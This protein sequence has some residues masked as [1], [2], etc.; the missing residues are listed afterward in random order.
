MKCVIVLSLVL[1]IELMF[2]APSTG[3]IL[4]Q[5]PDDPATSDEDDLPQGRG[6]ATFPAIDSDAADTAV[7]EEALSA[8]EI[9]RQQ[10]LEHPDRFDEEDL[11]PLRETHI[12][13]LHEAIDAKL[14]DQSFIRTLG[15]VSEPPKVHDATRD[16][17]SIR[18]IVE[19]VNFTH[20]DRVLRWKT[21]SATNVERHVV[22]GLTASSLVVLLERAGQYELSQELV[23]E[24]APIA[25]EVLNFWDT[26]R[27]TAVGCVLISMGNFL[28]WYTMREQAEYRL[29]EEWRW[30]LHKTITQIKFFRQKEVDALLLVGRHPNRH[31]SVS[32]TVY[33]FSFNDRQFWLM[34]KI[35]LKYPC[36]SVGLVSAGEEYL[37][38]FPQNTTV[39]MY[40]FRVGDQNRRK[41]KPVGNYTSEALRSVYAF[42]I[43][44]YSYVAISGKT[45]AVL[46][47]KRGKFYEQKIPTE[48]LEIVEA[49]FEIPARTYRDD[50][51]LL[52]Q[53]RMIFATHEIQRLEAL[54]WNGVSFDLAT[55]IPCMVE[56][57]V[58][59]N[60]VSCMLDVDRTDGLFGAANVQR[61]KSISIVVPRH[62]AHSS[63][64][65]LSI[66]LLSG[67]H[68]ILMKIQEIKET[69]DAFTKIIDYQNAVIEQAQSYVDLME[70]DP[71]VL[72]RQNLSTLDSPM[73]KFADD[74]DLSTAQ[75]TIGQN[76]WRAADF[77]ADLAATVKTVQD[78]ELSVDAMLTELQY[79]VRR[80][81]RSHDLQIN[82]T[83]QVTGKLYV[84][85][86]LHA[87]DMYIQ[88]FEQ[89]RNIEDHLLRFG[90]A[91]GDQTSTAQELHVKEL[92]VEQL[93][94]DHFNGIP[95]EELVYNVDGRVHLD[96]ELVVGG[97]LYTNS[98]LL[99]D[100]GTVN[101]IDLSESLIYFNCKNRRWKNLTLDS[102][103]VMD[104]VHVANKVN[105]VQINL[106]EAESSL[107]KAIDEHGRVLRAKSL[108]ID[109]DLS[110]E[111]I[112]GVPWKTFFNGLVFKNRPMRLR[113][114][115]VDGNVTFGSQTTVQFLNKLRFPEDY[116]LRTGPRESIITGQK[117]FL[118]SL[119]M[120]ALDIDGFVNGI[121]P[122]D[123]ITLHDDQYIPGNVSFD[124]L[125]IEESLDVRGAV[126]GKHMDKFLDNPS[127][128]Q[129]TLLNAACE[130]NEVIVQG[131]IFVDQ[132]DG[133]DLDHFLQSVVYVDEPYVEINASKH[134]RNLQ[135]YE[136]I[137]IESNM[138]GEIHLD[139]LLTKSTDQTVNISLVMGNV[140]FNRAQIDGLFGGINVTE[141][142]T[143]SIKLFGDQHTQATLEFCPQ[144]S[145]LYAK[146]LEIMGT[147][148]GQPRAEFYELDEEI[149]FRDQSVHVS[150]L[151]ASYLTLTESLIDGPSKMLNS[152]HLPTFDAYRFSLS[153]PQT[154]NY[155]VMIDTLYVGKSFAARYLNGLDVVELQENVE[156][157]LNDDY[158]LSG[159]HVIDTL[160][161]DGNVEIGML[162]GIDFVK[163]LHNVIWLD[164]PNSVPSTLH[165][166]QP[167]YVE[168]DVSVAGT[169]NEIPLAAF[170]DN[171]VYKNDA[172]TVVEFTGSKLFTQGFDVVGDLNAPTINNVPVKDFIL[173]NESIIFPGHV[174]T[175]GR[176]Y[177]KE[178]IVT[179]SINGKSFKPIE[180][181][182][183][184][185]NATDTH[186]I[187]GDL[188]LQGHQMIHN[189]EA[190]G[191]WNELMNVSQKLA[192]LVRTN[193]DYYFKGH[194][195]LQ[196]DVHFQHGFTVDFINGYNMT[197]VREEIVY[198]DQQEPIVFTEPV[199]F[200]ANVW[201]GS[202]RVEQD[203]IGKNL[204]G[205]DPDELAKQTL[206]V[207]KDYEIFDKMVFLPGAFKCDHLAATH[208]NGV[209][210][211]AL[212]T[213]HTEQTI[214]HPVYVKQIVVQHPLQVEGLVNGRDLRVER[215]NTVMRYGEQT[216]EASSVFNTIRVLN[217]ATLPKILN[218]APFGDPVQLTDDMTIS[219]PLSFYQ[220]AAHDVHS[221][222]T[223]GGIDFDRWYE[224]SLWTGG[225][226]HQVYRGGLRARKM[227]FRDTIH[228]NGTI[229]GATIGD[230]VRKLHTEK[231]LVESELSKRRSNYRTSCRETQA[232][233]NGTQQGLYFFNYFVQ[234]QTIR[235]QQQPIQSFWT[236][237]QQG[238][239]FLAIN[240]GCGSKFYQWNPQDRV[241]V[242]LF[243]VH[244]GY[245]FEWA[246][247]QD[248]EES[249][250]LITR[251]A[252]TDERCN[253]TGL[254]IWQFKG[255]SL[256]LGKNFPTKDIDS[257]HVDPATLGRFYVLDRTSVLEYDLAGNVQD[258]WDLSRIFESASFAPHTLGVGL[259]L[260][261][262]KQIAVLSRKE[263][264]A[265]SRK[266][267]SH[268]DD[269]L[270]NLALFA[271]PMNVYN[272]MQRNSSYYRVDD[273]PDE[274]TPDV[275][276]LTEPD[277]LNEIGSMQES[278]DTVIKTREPSTDLV[279]PSIHTANPEPRIAKAVPLG[280]IS[281]TENHHF[282][283]PATG[284]LLSLHVGFQGQARRLLV[285]V[286]QTVN[287]IVKGNHDTIRLYSDILQGHLF[288]IIPCNRPSQLTVLEIRDETILAFLEN[289]RKVQLYTYRGRKGFVHWNSFNLASAGVQM[290]S[291]QLPQAPFFKCNLHYLA[292]ALASRE[293]M[294][295][296][297][298]TQGDCGINLQLD[299]GS[300]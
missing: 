32:A 12:N 136:P 102:L 269:S 77:E 260:S 21:M 113:H 272:H 169:L 48:S 142:D 36:P 171:V 280:R 299:C 80:D 104:N 23:L 173:K 297:A 240:F 198:Y 81:T 101:G 45:P 246:S 162:N 94:F 68:P 273:T 174:V 78:V 134:Y 203:L 209:P 222:D 270:V 265:P 230:I 159:K 121:N 224:T 83:V 281:T 175:L 170:L 288:Q 59:D 52:V 62:E 245:V 177:V 133:Y 261:D 293:L 229:N 47:Y 189:L 97:D 112:N 278:N 242:G 202:V 225:R 219:S 144:Y 127:L 9:H 73:I 103:E 221:N 50:M 259:A 228:G 109:G 116:V 179:G 252:P 212:I 1:S 187:K 18:S 115:H 196:E 283:D 183:A 211:S 108:Q 91:V 195:V 201:G 53:H 210:T 44:R 180:A 264:T 119:T 43:G 124:L 250:H 99:P 72:K 145:L 287:T 218:G 294:F 165:F 231:Q 191:G 176:V 85:G 227:V 275:A 267:R 286:T 8:Y 135:F 26:E 156:T 122:F 296:K 37:V 70:S 114:L 96:G 185:S 298:K 25:F 132:L 13:V 61:G 56:N 7:T 111:R 125:E 138:I 49:F 200:H 29:E 82:G 147:L 4:K 289:H 295:L 167:L 67:E 181:Y 164:Q 16:T 88:R 279:E 89:P 232:V 87:D 40:T 206:L 290:T 220:I 123:F 149:V 282:P 129:T 193:Q 235:E 24:S 154:F 126:H 158:M 160:H 291:V 199:E 152:V 11:K 14:I 2:I 100:G 214:E 79:S 146:N 216:I 256:E 213:L 153:Q 106:H 172:G 117:H 90:R 236:F 84:D 168:G 166:L 27:A 33:E 92:S 55:N 98:V 208:I 35:G 15:S 58:I 107:R 248:D 226:E 41:F 163:F 266:K 262:G 184:Y 19:D 188:H 118:G 10:L 182:Y 28:V 42:Q 257:L 190:L 192:S 258:E 217:G 233:I 17:L 64:Y 238:N 161:I 263:T 148:N 254:S 223:I 243:Q 150:D 139:E 76:S 105:G 274:Y 71:V 186:I 20:G 65:H 178:M 86:A 249:L 194:Y 3:E 46:R 234:R 57:E 268:D 237:Q 207:N 54:V 75:I 155:D 60:E 300:V 276:L 140:F 130:F 6:P 284:E 157:Y 93:H 285:A 143:N 255:L 215:Q 277:P 244:T 241:F 51:I 247:V 292:I 30:P 239:Y 63:L 151:Y 69:M 251:S 38:A 141:W 120:D 95:A 22:V 31:E 204:M 34:Q 271:S 131:S 110:F 205:I 74:Y 128:L 66:E 253:V 137:R 197:N 5:D 39:E